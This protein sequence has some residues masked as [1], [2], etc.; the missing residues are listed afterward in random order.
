VKAKGKI[1]ATTIGIILLAGIAAWWFLVARRDHKLGT[2]TNSPPI[3][4]PVLGA[5]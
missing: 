4:N 3:Q 1:W 2:E 5:S